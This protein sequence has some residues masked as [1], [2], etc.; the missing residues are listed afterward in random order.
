MSVRAWFAGVVAA[1]AGYVATVLTAPEAS[2]HDPF[3]S[4]VLLPAIGALAVLCGLAGWFAPRG[5]PWW[6]VVVAAVYLVGV[7]LQFAFSSGDDASFAAL[8]IAVLL[9]LLVVPWLAGLIVGS[10]AKR[11]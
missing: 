4:P 3:D 8:G 10:V 6:G 11:R 2:G 7:S 5:G 1:A 9:V